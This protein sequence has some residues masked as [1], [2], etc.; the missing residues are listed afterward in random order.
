[1]TK[2]EISK[3]EKLIRR[4]TQLKNMIEEHTGGIYYDEMHYDIKGYKA[5]LYNLDL[6]PIYIETLKARVTA[7]EILYK[8]LVMFN[9][10]TETIYC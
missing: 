3:A 9:D 1:M 8:G 2:N 5:D 7:C 4:Y 6:E 10:E